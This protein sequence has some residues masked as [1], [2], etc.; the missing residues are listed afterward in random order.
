M[1]R[2]ICVVF[3]VVV[4]LILSV[5]VVAATTLEAT[6]SDIENL[7]NDLNNRYNM[8]VGGEYDCQNYNFNELISNVVHSLMLTGEIEGIETPDPLNKITGDWEYY[9]ISSDKMDYIL[10]NIFH[11][12]PNHKFNADY[13]G[14]C[15][16]YYY[17]NNY[18]YQ[19]EGLGGIN[20]SY[21]VINYKRQPDGKYNIKLL[22]SYSDGGVYYYYI[23]ADLQDLNGNRTWTFY[24]TSSNALFYDKETYNSVSFQI[25]GS[26]IRFPINDA[27]PTIYNNRVYV[28]IR[29]TCE[30]LG[31]DVAYDNNEGRMY[32]YNG[33]RIVSHVKNTST[34]Y[35]DGN[36]VYFDT[37][38][39]TING[40]T[41]MP[42][43]ML[44]ESIGL[45]V[46]WDS[47][48]KTVN[49]ITE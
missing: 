25:N 48:N 26:T 33:E 22:E 42:I 11:A 9:K 37:P 18:Y 7:E 14:W 41:L 4:V 40:R 24:N 3:M 19:F 34:V 36:A 35:V 45:G 20:R 15:N 44:A 47:S 39:I 21:S 10:T 28:P 8:F 30:Y 16:G 29:K 27:V 32:F 23:I 31:I 12:S 5:S 1:K 2:L 17:E 13:G 49:I 43:R 6:Q 46:N 38:S